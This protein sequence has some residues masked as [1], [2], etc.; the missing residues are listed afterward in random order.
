[1][2]DAAWD[3]YDDGLEDGEEARKGDLILC[4]K[5]TI[6]STTY[7]PSE[8]RVKLR[9]EDLE[10]TGNFRKVIGSPVPLIQ[11]APIISSL[12]R[13]EDLRLKQLHSGKHPQGD[14][15]EDE[16]AI[17]QE[18]IESEDEEEASNDDDQA[19]IDAGDVSGETSND[20]GTSAPAL[21]TLPETPLRQP[22]TEPH[23]SLRHPTPPTVPSATAG[24]Q[25]ESQLPQK[26]LQTQRPPQI[27]N[28][29]RRNRG[30]FSMGREG[31]EP[32]RG[33]NLT[34]PQAPTLHARQ[35]RSPV[36]PPRNKLLDVI[37][38]LP[39][40]SPRNLSPEPSAPVSAQVASED[41]VVET[42]TKGKRS[43]ETSTAQE[44]TPAP[45][46]RYR[47]PRDQKILLDSSSSWIPSAPGQQ[48]PHPNV[49]VAL[50]KTW[51][52]RATG[53]SKPPLQSSPIPTLEQ[54]SGVKSVEVV[55]PEPEATAAVEPDSESEASD[56]S[57]DESIPWSQSPSRSQM[58][59]PDSSAAHSP[60]RTSRPS[61]RNL[62]LSDSER[63]P[64]SQ[65]D[66]THTGP[67]G[68]I[69]SIPSG[70][71]QQGSQGL[72]RTTAS[73]RS[74][75]M[76]LSNRSSREQLA[77]TL[78][79]TTHYPAK[80]PV[81][82]S[83]DRATRIPSSSMYS[84]ALQS[85]SPG[86]SVPDYR[87]ATQPTTG[88]TPAPLVSRS[89]QPTPNGLKRAHPADD[90]FN[91]TV[92]HSTHQAF[93]Q[94]HSSSGPRDDVLAPNST[95]TPYGAPTGPRA[96]TGPRYTKPSYQ[97]RNM[98]LSQE[99]KPPG[100]FYRPS[101]SDSRGRL[102]PASSNPADRQQTGGSK[103]PSSTIEM[104]TAVP[105]PLP[106][107]KYREERSNFYRDAQRRKW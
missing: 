74:K 54:S 85:F 7:G 73:Q 1:M 76:T 52:T 19:D 25:I 11:R 77:S 87:T 58:L 67:S 44:S 98:G 41:I 95:S 68:A 24:A 35:A 29:L 51:N 83:L 91:T 31:F 50:L 39:G 57:E 12:K 4:K 40:Q 15:A 63:V 71:V 43:T 38:K 14:E 28:P 8:E 78:G 100:D 27:R 47:I 80:T 45:R 26:I 6:V 32:T 18:E 10:L 69:N 105:R 20:L 16:V 97:N 94:G 90:S 22:S 103:T 2:S 62:A 72:D 82:T 48:F 17:K 37:S 101:P 3:A 34:G 23:A 102:S 104:E 46:K 33:D 49:P 106:T 99:R 86:T 5:I 60:V 42:P 13:I 61:S 53:A 70:D 56:T 55:Q 75:E 92:R 30:G 59:P 107:S 65:S 36:E 79:Q 88:K 9:I 81:G 64:T 84:P 96:S 89:T 21:Q 66:Y 93:S